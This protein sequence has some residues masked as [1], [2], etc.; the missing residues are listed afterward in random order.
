MAE[1]EADVAVVGAGFAGIVAARELEK[2][3]LSVVVLEARDRVGGRVL[4]EPIGDGKVVEVGGQWVGPGQDRLYALAGEM[5]VDTFP[6]HTAGESLIEF[7]GQLK[8]YRGTIPR[9][10]AAVLADVAQAQAKFERL[11]RKVD[12]EAPWRTPGAERLDSQTFWSWMR[13]NVYTPGGRMLLEL[14]VEAVWAAE[15]ADVSLLHV[16]FYVASAGSYDLLVDTEGG[17]QQDRFVGGSQLVAERAAESLGDRVILGAP[18]RKIIHKGERVSVIADGTTAWCR[19][20]VVAIPPPLAGRIAYDPPLPGHR[21]QLTQRMPMGSVVKCMAIYDEPFWR[22]DGLSGTATSDIGPAKVIFDNS[23]PDGSPGVLLGFLEGRRA[24][25]LT[26]VPQDERRDAVVGTF[27]RLFGP[28][29]AKPER[30]L[31]KSWAEE[32]WTRG[33]Y[34][35]YLPPGGWTTYGDA[36]KAPIGCI[37]WAGSETSSVWM[38]YIDGAIRSGER[39]AAEVAQAL[40]A[41]SSEPL[42]AGAA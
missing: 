38:G 22:A 14:G 31:D 3:G 2:R 33:C 26:R 8:R 25:E 13:R 37:H 30:Y 40:Q 27:A 28:R 24:R 17:A 18:V 21:D 20:V 19:R 15:P 36:I 41:G 10:N 32:E 35:G 6:T 4:N 9:I 1:Y 34:G 7:R 42:A 11:A 29:A 16:L 39:V 12:V 5:G 23:P